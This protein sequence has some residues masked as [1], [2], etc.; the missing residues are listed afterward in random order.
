MIGM[1]LMEPS[2]VIALVT[3]LTAPIATLAA[4]ALN[5]R[6][7]KTD[8]AGSIALASGEAVD[9]IKEVMVTL[10]EELQETKHKL[11]EFKLQNKELESSLRALHEQNKVLLEQNGM[12][13]KEIA[14]LKQQVDRF[15]RSEYQ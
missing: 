8:L 12:L 3:L 9:A 14:A 5:R 6:K 4:W 1:M 15:A 10:R 2:I 7:G 13:A 11:E